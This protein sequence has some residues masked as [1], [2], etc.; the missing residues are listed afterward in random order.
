MLVFNKN[1]REG[2]SIVR[3][4]DVLRKRDVLGRVGGVAEVNVL[5]DDLLERLTALVSLIKPGF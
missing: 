2:F 3:F 1:D 4:I 5:E